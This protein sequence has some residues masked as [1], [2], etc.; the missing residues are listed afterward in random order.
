MKLLRLSVFSLLGLAVATALAAPGFIGPKVEEIWKQQL[1]RLQGGEVAQYQRGWFGAEASTR[2]ESGDG[3]TELRSEIQH[4]PLLFTAHGPRLG[5]V[6]T[7]TRLSPDHLAPQLRA[8]LEQWYGRLDQSPLVLES[9]VGAD[10]RIVNYLRLASF[11]RADSSGELMF[12]G[13]QLLIETDYSGALL[14][15]SLE[16][17]SIRHTRAG[18]EALFTEP[19]EGTFKYTPGAGGEAELLLPLLRAESESGPLEL[20][21]IRLQ[22]SVEEVG[23]GLLKLISDLKLPQVQSATPVTALQ[24]QMTLPQVAATDLL[25][26]LSV[27]VPDAGRDW[28]R[29]MRRPLRLQQ[30]LAVQS[31]NGPVLVDADIDWHGT[32]RGAGNGADWW[33][34]PLAG[35]VTFSAAEQALMQ[36]P[37]VA[38]AMMLRQYGLLMENNGELQ[39]HLQADRGRLLVNGQQLPPDLLLLALTGDF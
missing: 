17:G 36:S 39:M 35:T 37:L 14:T 2:V 29:A 4:G 32:A 28:P 18:H 38:K 20:R 19:A 31:R 33:L 23:R 26:Y 1:A 8:Q 16:L 5:V 24:Q 22:L 9:L 34:A 30:Q 10:N 27:L 3:G 6:Y 21:D 12:D 25:H 13:G 11:T 15:G 7:E